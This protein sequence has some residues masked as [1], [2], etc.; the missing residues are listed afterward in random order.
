MVEKLEQVRRSGDNG[1]HLPVPIPSAGRQSLSHKHRRGIETS[2]ATPSCTA[3]GENT[4]DGDE[5]AGNYCF[6]KSEREF[7]LREKPVLRR[8]NASWKGPKRSL[9][10]DSR[11]GKSAYRFGRCRFPGTS[12]LSTMTGH[13]GV[14]AVL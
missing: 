9:V 5:V 11:S 13:S 12:A 6:I 2:F 1:N 3:S 7:A 8:R 4:T 14:S 10:P